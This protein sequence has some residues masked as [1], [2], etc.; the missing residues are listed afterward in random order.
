M[1]F[2]PKR[3]WWKFWP[4]FC[5][6]HWMFIRPN[7]IC[8]GC[9][10]AA[11]QRWK[12]KDPTPYLPPAPKCKN[13]GRALRGLK[14]SPEIPVHVDTGSGFCDAKNYFSIPPGSRTIQAPT[15]R[16]AEWSES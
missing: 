8:D 3:P 1:T 7:D 9:F 5:W 13:C 10:N 11:K 6:K 16:F 4:K 12:V 14:N 2:I 15:T